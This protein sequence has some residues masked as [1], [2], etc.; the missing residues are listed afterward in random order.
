ME[1][2]SQQLGMRNC[3]GVWRKGEEDPLIN[4]MRRE[5]H[6]FSQRCEELLVG[7]RVRYGLEA[8]LGIGTDDNL[9]FSPV[10]NTHRHPQGVF[11]YL[12]CRDGPQRQICFVHDEAEILECSDDSSEG[13][14]L[15]R[16][17]ESAALD[18]AQLHLALI[19]IQ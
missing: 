14:F 3:S 13:L 18:T 1:V 7:F 12:C 19:A 8:K 11:V 15:V 16:R 6:S 17:I 5:E 4:L 10:A 9:C 2:V